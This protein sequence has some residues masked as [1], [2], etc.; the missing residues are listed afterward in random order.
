MTEFSP[1][2]LQKALGGMDYPADREA[3]VNCA[4]KNKAEDAVIERLSNLEEDSFDGPNDVSK[5]VFNENE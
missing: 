5:A 4:R 2:A 3:L 1:I